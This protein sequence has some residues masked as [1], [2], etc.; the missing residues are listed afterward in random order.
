[1]KGWTMDLKNF[2]KNVNLVVISILLKGNI[3]RIISTYIFQIFVKL[4]L[5][6]AA[7]V[8]QNAR[9]EPPQNLFEHFITLEKSSRNCEILKTI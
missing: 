9:L 3:G 8:E 6:L 1:M 7:G 4:F 2:K 5:A